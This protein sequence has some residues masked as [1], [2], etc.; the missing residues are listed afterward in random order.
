ML[1]L[2]RLMLLDFVPQPN[3]YTY[4]SIVQKPKTVTTPTD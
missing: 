1:V 3:L 4:V 2:A